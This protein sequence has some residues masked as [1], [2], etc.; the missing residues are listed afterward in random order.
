MIVVEFEDVS[1][2]QLPLRSS[3]HVTDRSIHRSTT[4]WP[5]LPASLVKPSITCTAPLSASPTHEPVESSVVTLAHSYRGART[6]SDDSRRNKAEICRTFVSLACDTLNVFL[7]RKVCGATIPV[8]REGDR[9][10]TSCSD[11]ASTWRS[12]PFRT[13]SGPRAHQRPLAY[14]LA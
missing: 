14:P 5:A 13:R 2:T 6:P 11:A 9:H 7:R 12:E 3:S 4:P 1:G 8:S 10:E